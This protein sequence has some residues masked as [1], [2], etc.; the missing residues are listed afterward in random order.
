M[1]R[2]GPDLKSCKEHSH[3]CR[4]V[5]VSST[6]VRVVHLLGQDSGGFQCDGCDRSQSKLA[7]NNDIYHCAGA[8]Q[9]AVKD[10]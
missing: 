2:C 9:M 1:S 6:R 3:M 7:L 10:H 4:T 5:H 8:V